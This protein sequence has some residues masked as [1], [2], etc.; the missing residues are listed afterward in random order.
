MIGTPSRVT[1]TGTS[2]KIEKCSYCSKKGY[3]SIKHQLG[4][5]CDRECLENF[6][7]L[8][9]TEYFP[10]EL[11][12]DPCLREEV[13]KLSPILVIPDK[14]GRLLSSLYMACSINSVL[15]HIKKIDFNHFLS[16]QFS[17]G[18]IVSSQLGATI[19]IKEMAAV[20]YQWVQIVTGNANKDQTPIIEVVGYMNTCLNK[21]ESQFGYEVFNNLFGTTTT[22]KYTRMVYLFSSLLLNH[23]NKI[24]DDSGTLKYVS[25]RH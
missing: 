22:T 12:L 25:N 24:E 1:S 17:Q 6:K 3:N 20:L 10:K 7:N 15:N 21:M 9:I 18:C 16:S 13:L 14:L 2:S 11:N 23:I 5:L 19:S 4:T 8:K